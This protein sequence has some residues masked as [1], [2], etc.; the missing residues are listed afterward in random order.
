MRGAIVN[1]HHLI[2]RFAAPSPHR[3]RNTGA[4]HCSGAHYQKPSPLR[5]RRWIFDRREKRRM[6]GRSLTSTTSS[7]APRHL[8]LKGE[9]TQA[10]HIASSDA[11]DQKPSLGGRWLFDRREKR[12]MRG[13]KA[14]LP[15]KLGSRFFPH[16]I[17]AVPLRDSFPQGKP[18]L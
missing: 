11:A 9:G 7:G 12:R 5:W 17:A 2:R 3:G 18:L 14:T 8:P 10:Q 16:H 15:S 1:I 6:R 4:A 13:K